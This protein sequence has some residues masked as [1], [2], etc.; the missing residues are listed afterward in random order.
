MIMMI[1]VGREQ[2]HDDYRGQH[3]LCNGSTIQINSDLYCFHQILW[4]SRDP[5]HSLRPWSRGLY[6]RAQSA[7]EI[8]VCA[9][10]SNSV[11]FRGWLRWE[12][13]LL[14]YSAYFAVQHYVM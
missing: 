1:L 13:V 7:V 10:V 6:V 4:G 3:A 8:K 14:M 12:L 5:N 9:R 2:S 11:A